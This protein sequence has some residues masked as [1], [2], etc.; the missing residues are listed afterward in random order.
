MRRGEERGLET[1]VARR[2]AF[3]LLPARRATRSVALVV[4]ALAGVAL[5]AAAVRTSGQASELVRFN[6]FESGGP[7]DYATGAGSPVGSMTHRTDAAGRF[8]LQ[9]AA[10]GGA[11]EYVQLSLDTPVTAFTDGIWACVETAPTMGA[12]R[13]R[14]WMNGNTVVA[15]LVLTPEQAAAADRQ[16]RSGRRRNHGGRR[17]PAVL[18][19]V[20]RVLEGAERD[21]R[22]DRRRQ[23]AQRYAL[24]DGDDRRIAHRPR[25]R[26][27]G[28][29]FAS[30]G[31]IMGWLTA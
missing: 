15:Q 20:R 7:G 30:C 1:T 24:L 16:R 29:R 8:G 26:W 19:G 11:N 13:V 28:R 4:G 9:T 6:G 22:A 17:L 25:R 14:S 10:G 12:R 18:V 31:T 3:V 23:P 27:R 21:G 5:A 2:P